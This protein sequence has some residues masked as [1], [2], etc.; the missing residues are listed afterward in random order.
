[1]L[2]RIL[3]GLGRI[4]L[5]SGPDAAQWPVRLCRLGIAA[6]RGFTPL[7]FYL[8]SFWRRN[9]TLHGYASLRWIETE[10]RPRLNPAGPSRVLKDKLLFHET[11]VA[12]S[13]PIARVLGFFH[14]DRPPPIPVR[15]LRTASDL[16]SAIGDWKSTIGDSLVAK[17]I[18]SLGGKGM[19]LLSLRSADSLRD[20]ATGTDITL[21]ELA[22][23]MTRDIETRQSREDSA[24][25]Y[26]LQQRITCHPAL[27]PLNGAA[28][29][30][31]RIATLRDAQGRIHPDFAMLRLARPGAVSDNLHRGGTV[32]NIALDSGRLVGPTLGYENETGPFLEP[33]PLDVPALF[34]GAKIPCWPDLLAAAV[35]FH[36]VLPG[37]GSIGWDIALTPDGPLVLEGNDNWDMV[38][39]QVLAGPY[40]TADR[41]RILSA[42]GLRLP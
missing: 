27:N 38:V 12:N 29:N 20:A 4:R 26:L 40:L 5:G 14:P 42:L 18:A 39:A 15:H 41:R 33:K 25:G 2:R 11:G 30:T 22:A 24:N 8:Y 9:A 7:E 6:A 37:L 35:R 21:A 1:M 23:L 28:L 3:R 34:P 10:F 31:V 19:M 36:S 13:L 16:S 32:T 17:P